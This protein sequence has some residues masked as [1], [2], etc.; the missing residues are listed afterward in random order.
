VVPNDPKDKAAIL[1][2]VK[3]RLAGL[4]TQYPG[5]DVD[6]VGNELR[7]RIP[8]KLRTSHEEHFAEVARS[9]FGYVANPRSFPKWEKA[10]M[11]AKYQVTTKG[12]DLSRQAA[13]KVAERI[14]PR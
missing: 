1:A 14:A 11:L 8:D 3:K 10:H 5:V 2:G 6:E 4:Q 13:V 12:A 9:F 7:L